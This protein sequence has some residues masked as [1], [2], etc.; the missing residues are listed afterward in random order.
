MFFEWMTDPSAWAG[1]MTLIVLEIVLGIDN[2]VFLTIASQRLPKNQRARA[3][4][5][6]LS[7]AVPSPDGGDL[8]AA[9]RCEIIVAG[10]TETLSDIPIRLKKKVRLA[11][12]LRLF[13]QEREVIEEASIGWGVD[14]TR[15][16]LQA[17]EPPRDIQQSMELQMRAEREEAAALQ[18]LAS[19]TLPGDEA[20]WRDELFDTIAQLEQCAVYPAKHFVTERPKIERAV[21]ACEGAPEPRRVAV[22]A[23]AVPAAGGGRPALAG[24][25]RRSR[26]GSGG[27][28]SVVHDRAMGRPLGRAVLETAGVSIVHETV[29]ENRFGFTHA[30]IRMGAS[31]QV[32]RECLGS[33]PCRFGQ[34]N[35]LHSAVIS[36]PTQLQG[37][38]IDIPDLRGGFSHLI[39]ALAA[40]GTSRV[41]GIE[42]INRGY[43]RFQ[44]KLENLGADFDI[45]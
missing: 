25:V 20:R 35:F 10:G 36:G 18:K 13:G 9:G 38:D 11:P 30:L 19:Q 33:I 2:L 39:A 22:V 21:G 26:L 28:L 31:I 34:R 5:L 15:V 14:V 12:P 40:N 43:E 32:H 6:G 41:T 42:L 7:G 37:T 4:R 27:H 24:A 23:A 17:I 45:A 1:L 44:S 29:Y 3:Q 8:I 16:E